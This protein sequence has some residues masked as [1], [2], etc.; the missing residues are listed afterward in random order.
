[1][2]KLK[3]WRESGKGLKTRLDSGL[4]SPVVS[5]DDVAT[6]LVNQSIERGDTAQKLRLRHYPSINV[7]RDQ[8]Y[9]GYMEGDKDD[10]EEMLFAMGYR[11]NPTAY[12]E[13][14]EEHGPDDGSYARQYITEGQVGREREHLTNFPTL[15]KRI[16]RQK[17]VVIYDTEDR[18][19]FLVHDET[20]AWLQPALH[21]TVN[22]VDAR[23]GVQEF[24]LDW[25]DEHAEELPG[26]KE[27]KWEIAH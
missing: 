22:D 18:V 12:V 20:S 21:V 5:R 10:A 15:F 13:V 7:D 27:V 4:N 26:S 9:A 8:L 16:K 23:R 14:T 1:M 11:N 6:P 3:L 17:H 2:Q 24:R 19:E 25:F